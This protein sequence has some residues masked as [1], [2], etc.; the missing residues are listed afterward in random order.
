MLDRAGQLE[1]QRAQQIGQHDRRARRSSF[2][3]HVG[4]E[5]WQRLAAQVEAPDRQLDAVDGGVLAERPARSRA[6]CRARAPARSRA[7]PAAIASTPEPVPTSS[8]GPPCPPRASSS[9]SS[10]RHSRVLAWP[11]VPKACPGSMTISRAPALRRRP[12]APRAGA[13][14]RRDGRGRSC[15]I[16]GSISTGRWKSFQRS[17]QS[18]AISLV[19]ISTSAP[20]TIASGRAA[21]GSSPGR[22]V[23]DVLDRRRRRPRPPRRRPGRARAA[24]RAPARP[25]RAR[26]RTARRIT[27]PGCR[28]AR[29]SLANID[30]CE[31]RFSS[32]RLSFRRSSSSRCSA[33]QPPRDDHV[34]DDPQVALASAPQPGHA[35]APDGE[36][37]ARL[38]ARGQLDRGAA[39]ERRH[40]ERRAERS[41]RR[42]HV[43]GG[44]QVVAFAHEALVLADADQHVE[45]ARRRAGG[46]PA[47]PCPLIRMRCPSAMPAG[48]LDVQA[49]RP[50]HAPASA[51]LAG[52]APSARARRRRRCRRRPSASSGRSGVRVTACSWPA[53][54]Q[55][56]QVSIGVPGSAPLPW[57]CSQRSTA[58]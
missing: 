13:R 21:P 15:A 34:D 29:R 51:A 42:G 55:R 40:L 6:R 54:P 12:A 47:W 26:T 52:T 2:A 32:V 30:S 45:V 53:P 24:R 18:S 41:Q 39:L 20:P 58:S 19:E 38:R 7:S 37:L 44:D 35:L 14:A 10:P 50:S 1:Q 22:A 3:D 31:R 17:C 43:E 27:R 25:A 16:G 57:Q 9:S 49:A 11:P 5:P 28:S 4:A 48:H 36:H 56:S 46:S 23:D 8:S 33:L